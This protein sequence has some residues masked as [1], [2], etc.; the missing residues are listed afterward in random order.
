MAKFR[1][2]VTF[3]SS[4]LPNPDVE[5]D[6]PPGREIAEQLEQAL[7]K[8][9]LQIQEPTEQHESYGWFF[10]A[11]VNGV[12]VWCM[13]QRS[14]GWMLICQPDLPFFRK[15]QPSDVEAAHRQ[16]VAALDAALRTGAFSQVLWHHEPA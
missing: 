3:E 8:A 11:R 12:A 7:R 6:T 13:L 1:S 10:T 15:P 16:T 5:A 9:A 2:S 14:D 4:L